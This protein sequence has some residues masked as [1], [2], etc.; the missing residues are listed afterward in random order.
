[1]ERLYAGTLP[2]RAV[3]ITFDDGMRDFHQLA[4]P[5][6]HEFGYP[7]TVYLTTY[8][9]EFNRPVFDVMCSYLLWKARGRRLEWPEVIDH[10]V[11]LDDAGRDVADRRIKIFARRQDLSGRQ[12]PNC[13]RRWR[14]NWQSITKRCAKNAFCM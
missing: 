8:Y 6:L 7:V 12:K 10:P 11:T 4:Y 5:L 9:S 13:C 3:T 2:K 1:V 14:G